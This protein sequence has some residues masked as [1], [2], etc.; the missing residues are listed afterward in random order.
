[1]ACITRSLE[2]AL[3]WIR[4]KVDAYL[5]PRTPRGYVRVYCPR[6]LYD[7]TVHKSTLR[8]WTITGRNRCGHCGEPLRLADAEFFERKRAQCAEWCERCRGVLEAL[9][10]VFGEV[11]VE[12]E[13]CRV[14]R[15][16]VRPPLME[17]SAYRGR[18][19]GIEIYARVRW[20]YEEDLGTF[21]A[22]VEALQGL[23]EKLPIEKLLIA[24]EEC[25]VDE[26]EL[27]KLGFRREHSRLVLRRP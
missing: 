4:L 25:G 26:G 9:L 15:L 8:K 27:M 19:G 18:S 6:C 20:L 12:V 11:A 2:E 5:D 16:R 3:Q 21:K 10:S 14:L 17:V 24:V 22:A 13:P 23:G 1:M 7:E